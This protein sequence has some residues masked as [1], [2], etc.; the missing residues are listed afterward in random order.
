MQFI[1]NKQEFD[2]QLAPVSRI[3]TPRSTAPIL[4]NVLI[5]TEKDSVRLTATDGELT[6]SASLPARVGQEGSFSVPAKLLQEFVHQNPDNEL[7]VVL[8]S[9]ELL[10]SSAK[11]QGRISG[12]DPEEFPLFP[13]VTDGTVL[14]LPLQEFIE[15]LK[16]VVVACAQDA[17]RPV[18]TGVYLH[19][20]GDAATIAATDSFRLSEK[21]IMIRPIDGE[22]ILLIPARTVQEIIRISATLPPTDELKLEVSEQQLLVRLGSVEIYSRLLVGN[23]PNYTAIIPKE[24]E[25]VVEVA[26]SELVQALR[27]S[28]IFAI[29]GI[30][31]VRIEISEDGSLSLAAHGSQRGK[32]THTLY[33][34]PEEGFKPLVAAFNARYL[35]DAV[36]A[37]SSPSLTLKFSGALKPLVILNDNPNY[38]QLVMPIRPDA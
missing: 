28:T 9:F 3:V 11:V 16:Q 38:L 15:S 34:V 36:Q 33:A 12:L 19:V 17:T 21:R 23:F 22:R 14:Q 32:A 31:N 5:A 25:V 6:I 2:R 26:T 8:E 18:L 4:S 27:L 13:T 20:Q 7:T 30:A 29:G 10:I 24:F 35:L 1:V 37:P